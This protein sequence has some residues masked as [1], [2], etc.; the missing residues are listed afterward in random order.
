MDREPKKVR[1]RVRALTDPQPEFVSLVP[2]GANMTP[3]TAI[4]SADGETVL[5][6]DTHTVVRLDF[7]KDKFPDV[8]AV[9]KWLVD[10]GYSGYSIEE[11]DTGFV[12]QGDAD[13]SETKKIE[14]SGVTA[15]V[16]KT[17]ASGVAAE[18]QPTVIEVAK[19]V[20]KT[21]VATVATEKSAKPKVLGEQTA[22]VRTKFDAWVAA[23]ATMDTELSEVISDA[24][25]DMLPPG[26]VDVTAAMYGALRNN[27]AQ[28]DLE[29]IR[30]LMAEYAEAII[31]LMALFPIE[32]MEPEDAERLAAKL[33]PELAVATPQP[34]PVE[35]SEMTVKTEEQTP[36]SPQDTSAV[37]TVGKTE[38]VAE[39]QAVAEPEAPVAATPE[40]Q[41]EEAAR[42]ETPAET[43]VPAALADALT[44]LVSKFDAFATV[45]KESVDTINS[46]VENLETERQSRKGA[47]DVDA[48]G[49]TAPTS[50][51]K[52]D[53]HAFRVIAFRNAMGI[54]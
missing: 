39:T 28:N 14:I 11:S 19:P 6:A 22:E 10:G 50:A 15:Y 13:V 49:S 52:D 46:R 8:E 31:G 7:S 48:A 53:D 32:S 40:T 42:T 5:R 33:C 27:V 24:Q 29:G 35:T 18:A 1:R 26:F 12:V 25:Y 54:R 43:Q 20:V 44:A 2:A 38:P 17:E 34:N 16:A 4:K 47:D 36:A 37:E 9:T 41:T 23:Y 45:V 30:A 51:K 3:F 21:A